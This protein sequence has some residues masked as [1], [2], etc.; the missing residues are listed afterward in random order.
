MA[1]R[2]Y[3]GQ[4]FLFSFQEGFFLQRN[5]ETLWKS[6]NSMGKVNIFCGSFI[7][8]IYIFVCDDKK[9]PLSSAMQLQQES[10]KAVKSRFP[11]GEV[12]LLFLYLVSTCSIEKQIKAWRWD[13]N[14]RIF[15]SLLFCFFFLPRSPLQKEIVWHSHFPRSGKTQEQVGPTFG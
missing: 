15:Y 12:H 8:F 7:K 9:K 14:I 5:Q 11:E 13:Y 1:E 3:M 10:H 2:W 4:L 6:S